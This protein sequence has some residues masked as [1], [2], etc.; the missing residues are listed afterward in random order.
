MSLFLVLCCVRFILVCWLVFFFI[1]FF[2]CKQKTAY[3]MRI[4][5]WSSDVCS[6]DLAEGRGEPFQAERR[7]FPVRVAARAAHPIG[8]IARAPGEGA[9][10]VHRHRGVIAA[11]GTQVT[12]EGAT[13]GR[14]S[15]TLPSCGYVSVSWRAL[16]W[17]SGV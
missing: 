7:H 8:Q 4:S 11:R 17:N 13:V 15:T 5:D 9:A 12:I 2:F 16:D 3:E 14:H 10:Q 1:F 6:S